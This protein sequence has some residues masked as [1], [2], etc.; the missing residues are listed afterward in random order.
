VPKLENYTYPY[1]KLSRAIGIA[2]RACGA[3]YNGEISVSGLAQ[4]LSMSETGGGFLYLVA[5]L[6]DYGL[7]EGTG[8]LRATEIAKKIVAGTSEEMSI[9]RAE[10]FLKVELFR[11]LKEKIGI[12][13]PET[14]Q[15]SVIL[16]DLTQADPLKVKKVAKTIRNLYLDGVPYIKSA[17]EEEKEEKK[18]TSQESGDKID[19]NKA[20]P[21]EGIE[22]L[23]LGANIKVW[24]PKGDKESAKK[25][26]Q[27]IKL[28]SGITEED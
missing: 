8:N 1:I 4:E 3:P 17:I 18:L 5:A 19:A 25:A 7:M 24:L 20:K 12:E 13:V 22:Q 11:K 9:N 28:Y 26:I 15:F 2:R 23:T 27:L 21:A 16:R 14:A 10:S 6:R